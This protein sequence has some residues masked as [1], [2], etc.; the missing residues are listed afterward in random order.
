M[1]NAA[2]TQRIAERFYELCSAGKFDDAMQELYA[3]DAR[4]VEV[5]EM[6]GSPYKRITAGKPELLR[7]SEHWNRTT[8]VHSSWVG[9]PLVNDDQFLIEFKMEVTASEGPMAGQRMP[10]AEHAL[11]TVKNGRIS[12]ARFFYSCEK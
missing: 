4:H 11:Y 6:P 9:R 5:M 3:D 1:S 8:T 10:L 2:A 12:E 7:M